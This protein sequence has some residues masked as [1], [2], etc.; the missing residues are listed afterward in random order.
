MLHIRFGINETD[1]DNKREHWTW[2]SK[3]TKKNKRIEMRPIEWAL[4]AWRGHF[5]FKFFLFSFFLCVSSS[6]PLIWGFFLRSIFGEPIFG[7]TTHRVNSVHC[8][9]YWQTE[10]FILNC[11]WQIFD[12]LTTK[13]VPKTDYPRSSRRLSIFFALKSFVFFF[14][15]LTSTT[16]M[17]ASWERTFHSTKYTPPS[18]TCKPTAYL[19]VMRTSSVRLW[20]ENSWKNVSNE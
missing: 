14:L 13:I 11:L 7:I 15:S 17:F 1:K 3:Q 2:A 9:L 4:S 5:I 6:F 16:S 10:S 8:A 12:S 20:T 19:A 18:T